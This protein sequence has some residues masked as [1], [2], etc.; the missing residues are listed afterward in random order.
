M[1]PAIGTQLTRSRERAV[2]RRRDPRRCSRWCPGLPAA[3][4]PACSPARRPASPGWLARPGAARPRATR[5]RRSPTAAPA[6]AR[7]RRRCKDLLP[8][9]PLEV[10]VG[11]ALVPLVDEAQKRRPAAAHR[12]SCASSWRWSSAS[13]CRRRAFATTSSSRRPSTPSSCAASAWPAARCCRATCWRSTPPASRRR[14]TGIRTTDPS[15]GMPAV[16]ITPERRAEAE[17]TGYSVVEPQTVLSTH[18]MET[19]REHAGRPALPAERARAAR[20]PEGDPPRAGRR[21]RPGQAVAR[22][23]APGA[24]AAAA[25]RRPDPRPGH[26]PRGAVRRGRARPRTPRR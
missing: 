14:S 4:V 6:R 17:A 5:G 19:I 10:E 22:H 3:A 7:S 2:D 11:Y 16:W 15:F 26:D 12:R 8:V 1:A 18:L 20:R 21:H 9:E 23:R 24:A 13:S 25:R